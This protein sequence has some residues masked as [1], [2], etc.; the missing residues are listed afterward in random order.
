MSGKLQ[1]KSISELNNAEF[2]LLIGGAFFLFTSFLLFPNL[3]HYMM[4]GP[5][6]MSYLPFILGLLGLAMI[7]LSLVKTSSSEVSNLERDTNLKNH[8]ENQ[9]ERKDNEKLS[10]ALRLLND[11][12]AKI[13]RIIHDNEGITQDSLHFRTGFSQSKISM[14]MKKLEER[15]LIVRERFGKTYKI[16][17]SEWL[18]DCKNR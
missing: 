10:V 7:I 18:R 5:Y 8:E 12:E 13:L 6:Y 3:H 1:V 14:I 9:N 2:V 15:D 11:D 4:M 16:Y 17:L